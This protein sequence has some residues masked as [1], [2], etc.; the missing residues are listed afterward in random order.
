[1]LY[2]SRRSLSGGPRGGTLTP[3][4]AKAIAEA[5]KVNMTLTALE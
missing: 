4:G 5:L 1:M 3:Q 2:F